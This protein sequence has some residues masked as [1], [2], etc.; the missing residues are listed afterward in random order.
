M[1]TKAPQDTGIGEVDA[2]KQERDDGG[3]WRRTQEL[4][5][6]KYSCLKHQGFGMEG[7]K[8]GRGSRSRS[9]SRGQSNPATQCNV[10]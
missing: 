5:M 7:A 9:R 4:L 10:M 6:G 2:E 1:T 3:S 8:Q